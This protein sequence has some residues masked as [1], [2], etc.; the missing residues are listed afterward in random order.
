MYNGCADRTAI[1]KPPC[2][3]F[4]QIPSTA[5][6]RYASLKICT[7][8]NIEKPKTEFHKRTKSKDGLFYKCK[9]CVFE[10]SKKFYEENKE[11]K[12]ATG[13]KW[14]ERNK[15]KVALYREKYLQNNQERVAQLAREWRQKNSE[16][17]TASGIAW[18][19]ANR[20]KANEMAR[21]RRAAKR[22]AEGSHTVEEVNAIFA[23]QRGLCANCK[24]KLIQNGDGK[25]HVDH[26]VPLSKGGSNWA[27]NLQCLCPGCNLRKAAKHPL[28]WAKENGKLL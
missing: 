14:V 8:C 10:Y 9:T 20:G 19:A 26:I 17:A 2:Q 11:K 6:D 28:D 23:R 22:N 16:R 21:N 5:T 3:W 27:S 24:K 1:R 12:L 18:R 13:K 25:Y 15:E 7:Q 4:P